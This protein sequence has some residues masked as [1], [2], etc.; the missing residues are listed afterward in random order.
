VLSKIL[1]Q[2]QQEALKNERPSLNSRPHV[3]STRLLNEFRL[4][5]L[6]RAYSEICQANS[7]VIRI[8]VDEAH[9]ENY[10]I[11]KRHLNKCMRYLIHFFLGLG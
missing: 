9:V 11:F 8:S 4:N 3:S 10:K 1:T 6:R 7:I 2:A 5:F